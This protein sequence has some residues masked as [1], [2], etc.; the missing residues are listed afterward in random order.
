MN[1]LFFPRLVVFGVCVIAFFVGLYFNKRDDERDKV[2]YEEQR[3]RAQEREQERERER[4][5]VQ[6]RLQEH[7]RF[8]ERLQEGLQALLRAGQ[9]SSAAQAMRTEESQ[10]SGLGAG[11]AAQTQGQQPKRTIN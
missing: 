11:A 5:L 9:P 3:K 6:E 4:Q 10:P 2:L 1:N 8:Q 7:E